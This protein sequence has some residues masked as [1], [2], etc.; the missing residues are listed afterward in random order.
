MLPSINL[1]LPAFAIMVDRFTGETDL[2]SVDR[3]LIEL[4]CVKYS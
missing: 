4:V 2:D 3:F 1:R